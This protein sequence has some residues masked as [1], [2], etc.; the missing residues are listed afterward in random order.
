MSYILVGYVSAAFGAAIGFLACAFCAIA[1]NADAADERGHGRH[2]RPPLGLDSRRPASP[3]AAQ[4]PQP[5]GARENDRAQPGPH[6][7]KSGVKLMK[8]ISLAIA[9]TVLSERPARWS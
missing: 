1:A 7:P 5:N 9:V 8:A 6:V 4:A 3:A 2:R